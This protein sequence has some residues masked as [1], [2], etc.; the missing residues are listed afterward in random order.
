LPIARNT[1]ERLMTAPGIGSSS[2]SRAGN[3][4]AKKAAQ[5]LR[6]LAL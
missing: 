2:R 5:K 1:Y 4:L 6:C 3:M